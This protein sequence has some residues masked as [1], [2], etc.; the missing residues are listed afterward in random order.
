MAI[1]LE[2]AGVGDSGKRRQKEKAPMPM[3]VLK[4]NNAR[5]RLIKV[6]IE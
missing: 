2:F 6:S 4:W 3:S 1:S 5:G